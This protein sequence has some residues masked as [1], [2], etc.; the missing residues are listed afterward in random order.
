VLGLFGP[1]GDKSG[2]YTTAFVYQGRFRKRFSAGSS[3]INEAVLEGKFYE[4]RLQ[5]PE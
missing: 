3:I 4:L 2:V 5:H 1:K